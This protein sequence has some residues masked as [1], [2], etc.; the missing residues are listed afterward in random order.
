M[1]R[2]CGNVA[3][4]AQSGKRTDRDGVE[5]KGQILLVHAN[6]RVFWLFWVFGFLLNFFPPGDNC[7]C[8]K[9]K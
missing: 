5:S 8:Y 1:G 4:Q 3:H 6:L 9:V 7:M 2:H